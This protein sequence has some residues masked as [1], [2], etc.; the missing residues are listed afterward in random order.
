MRNVPIGLDTHNAGVIP[1]IGTFARE[2][3]N[4]MATEYVFKTLKRAG[5]VD[6]MT[7]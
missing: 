6:R 1:G 2:R 4:R 5:R 3:T 7:N